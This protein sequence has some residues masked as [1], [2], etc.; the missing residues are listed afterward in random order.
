MARRYHWLSASVA[1]Y[2]NEPHAAICAER[3]A[4]TLNLVASESAAVRDA[5][6]ALSREKPRRSRWRP[7]RSAAAARRCRAATR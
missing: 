7:I 6:A 5:S 1:S 3:A 2:V 4:P